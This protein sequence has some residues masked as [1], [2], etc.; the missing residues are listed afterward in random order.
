MASKILVNTIDSQSGGA[1]SI[2]NSVTVPTGKTVTIADAGA[3]TIGGSPITTGATQVTSTSTN[4]FTLKTGA[5]EDLDI[6]GKSYSVVSI[7]ASAG[8]STIWIVNLPAANTFDTTA[9]VI[10]SAALHGTGNSIEI[11]DS[12]GVE[13]YTLYEK[14]DHCEFVSDGTNVIRTGKEYT[15][16][17]GQITL[18]GDYGIPGNTQVDVV[19]YAG[20][21]NWIERVDTAGWWNSTD[22]DLDVPAGWLVRFEGSFGVCEYGVGYM[23]RD[24]DSGD[25]LSSWYDTSFHYNFSDP[26]AHMTIPF[27]TAKTVTFW[28]RNFTSA[29]HYMQGTSGPSYGTQIRWR[30]ERRL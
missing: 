25:F 15:T 30:V 21:A 9:I 22:L 12:G 17:W 16:V 2:A 10:S 8:T 23:L 18:N 6:T 28:G 5:G 20:A 27:T 13:V 1:I 14:G 24:G 11:R 7:D 26:P 3:L 29:T 19:D 4:P